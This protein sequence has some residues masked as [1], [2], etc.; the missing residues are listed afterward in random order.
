MPSDDFPCNK[1]STLPTMF[2]KPKAGEGGWDR[3]KQG[4]E[5]LG[6]RQWGL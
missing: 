5:E 6:G 4:R 3:Q 2:M 1:N